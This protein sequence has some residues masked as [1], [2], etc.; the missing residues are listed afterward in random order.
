MK[1][2]KIWWKMLIFITF[3]R[4]H[5][6]VTFWGRYLAAENV[7]IMLDDD[8]ICCRRWWKR[9]TVV[10]DRDDLRSLATTTIRDRRFF[11]LRSRSLLVLN[12]PWSLKTAICGKDPRF[13]IVI[14]D[15]D[16]WSTILEKDGLSGLRAWGRSSGHVYV[17]RIRFRV[18]RP[19]QRRQ[20]HWL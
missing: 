4:L 3:H 10:G 14:D 1:V 16:Q 20:W 17:W 2:T 7:K 19:P 11:S 6:T 8:K 13:T 18:H 9:S 12:D 5:Q 15:Q